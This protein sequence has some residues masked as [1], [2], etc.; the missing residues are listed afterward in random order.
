MK[1]RLERTFFCWHPPAFCIQLQKTNCLITDASDKRKR[2]HVKNISSTAKM[3][4]DFRNVNG[5]KMC[6]R[7]R[8][9]QCVRVCTHIYFPPRMGIKLNTFYPC[10]IFH[11]VPLN[12]VCFAFHSS[13]TEAVTPA[14]VMVTFARRYLFL[15]FA[16]HLALVSRPGGFVVGI[17]LLKAERDP[18]F[19][20][21]AHRPLWILLTTAR[22]CLLHKLSSFPFSHDRASSSE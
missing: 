12:A 3:P 2:N 16:L 11:F 17:S 21:T 14:V 10:N 20:A 7:H 1:I 4:S 18:S 9:I 13:D 19:A 8:K 15:S 22:I 5:V 6:I